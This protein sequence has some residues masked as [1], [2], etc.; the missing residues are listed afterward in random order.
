MISK[1]EILKRGYVDVKVFVSGLRQSHRLQIIR[2][3]TVRGAVPYLVCQHYIPTREL[4]RLAEELQLPVKYKE[5]T[6]FP[7]GKMAGDFTEKIENSVIAKVEPET[8]EAEI[9]E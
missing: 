4:V 8:V 3:N 5:V 1:D 9:E 2:E 7:K 6:I